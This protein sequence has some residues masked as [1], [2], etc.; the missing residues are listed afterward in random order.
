[1]WF[2]TVQDPSDPA[3]RIPDEQKKSWAKSMFDKSESDWALVQIIED[4]NQPD[5]VGTF[6]VMKMPKAILNR[7][8]AKMNPTD[9]KKQ[10]QPLMDYLFGPTLD[11]DVA[12]GPDDPDHPE[13]KQREISYDL[14]DFDTDP[15]PII[16]TDG[17][18]LFSDEEIEMI[19]DYNTANNDMLKAK[20]QSKRD[21]AARRKDELATQIRPLYAKAIDYIKTYAIDPVVECGYS[22]WS[23]ELATR[24]DNWLN[25]VLAMQDPQGQ[26]AV[27]K[28]EEHEVKPQ[29][30]E[31]P[32]TAKFT[33]SA[34]V[35][36]DLPF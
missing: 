10:K 13:R 22:P 4:E 30:K 11:M 3:K 16:S 2:A 9:P 32:A 27:E 28:P 31:E 1:L 34:P 5:L 21:E 8:L 14:C 25:K 35:I 36:D 18:P 12:P 7:L 26:T 20:T 29:K 6:K 23:D 19:E 33:E 17:T 15:C 24:V